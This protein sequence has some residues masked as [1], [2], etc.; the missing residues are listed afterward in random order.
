[1]FKRV[2][3]FFK[4]LQY[5][6]MAVEDDLIDSFLSE[7]E[8][9]LFHQLKKSEQVHSILVLKDFTTRFQGEAEPEILKAVLFHDIGKVLRPLSLLEKSL[10]VLIKNI[11]LTKIGWVQN[12]SFMSSYLNHGQRGADLLIQKDI[13]RVGSLEEILVRTHHESI[14]SLRD[15]YPENARI[16]ELHEILKYADDRN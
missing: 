14:D 12:L 11:N 3:Q 16:L 2:V 8:R 13:F 7:E 4:N 6:V 1:M 9:G 5:S 10:A 15:Q